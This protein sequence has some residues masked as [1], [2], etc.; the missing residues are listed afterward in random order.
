[1]QVKGIR[2]EACKTGVLGKLSILENNLRLSNITLNSMKQ[3]ILQQQ[4]HQFYALKHQSA[5]FEV[6]T[7]CKK[8]GKEML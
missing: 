8:S 7:H 4:I 1:M 5:N 3:W 2:R 6:A